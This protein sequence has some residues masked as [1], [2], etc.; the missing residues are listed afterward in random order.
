[1]K[2]MCDTEVYLIKDFIT[3]LDSG[4]NT[5][6][7]KIRAALT[8]SE[9]VEGLKK[10]RNLLAA[11]EKQM[12]IGEY[13]ELDRRQKL[14]VAVETSTSVEEI[15]QTIDQFDRMRLMH[16][17]LRNRRKLGRRLPGSQAES[18]VMLGAD[19]RSGE[20]G[21]IDSGWV[22]KQKQIQKKKQQKRR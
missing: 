12:P 2:K 8:K 13:A 4:L 17:W 21:L 18:E 9:E 14:T 6:G 15:N 7:V 20:K 10:S 19:I 5:W 11:I 3:E 16:G 22:A 1:M